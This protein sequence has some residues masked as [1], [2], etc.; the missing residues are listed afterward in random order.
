[1]SSGEEFPRFTDFW[2]ERP[3]ARAKQLTIYALLDSPRAAG[4]YEFV[5][6]PGPATTVDVRARLFLRDNVAKLGL[7]PVTSMFFFG[8]NQRSASEDFRPEVHDSDGLL[9]NFDTGEWLW[10]PLDNP[11]TLQVNTLQM[12]DPRGFGLIQRDRSFEHHQ[13]LET[14]TDLRP[15]VWISTHG[16]WGDGAV[17]LVE[18]PTDT[19][20]RDNIVA[21][22]VP[23]EEPKLGE[24]AA[25]SYT[26]YWYG[27]DP[28]RPPGGRVVATR[29]D[30]GTVEN[31]HRF[32]LDFDG[33]AL[34]ALPAE[35]A[36]RAVVT[37]AGGKETGDLLEQQVV[38]NAVTGGWR[39]SFQVRPKS[40]APIEIRAFLER[41]GQALTET[42][43]YA[44]L[45]W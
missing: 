34:R 17:E 23:R 31:V 2:I 19:D 24:P 25:F 39:L 22:W 18:I 26:L 32:V 29:R 1:V 5:L 42:W 4:A 27:D 3:A 36:P 21:Y 6:R 35:Q 15:S 28:A 12:H 10:R 16:E 45:P 11:Q 7:A 37:V 33:A 9:L 38:K 40:G 14:R 44:I 30:W 43:S 20:I 8:E 41:G 13:D